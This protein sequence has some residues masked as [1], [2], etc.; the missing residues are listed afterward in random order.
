MAVERDAP[1]G[2]SD[3]HADRVVMELVFALLIRPQGLDEDLL[4]AAQE[5]LTWRGAGPGSR[6][7]EFIE[8]E[9]LASRAQDPEAIHDDR[10]D[11]DALPRLL[12]QRGKATRDVFDATLFRR[13]YVQTLLKLYS[14][15]HVAARAC[16]R[17]LD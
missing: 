17:L 2:L 13:E 15:L 3:V 1:D 8:R 12:D 16:N 7:A 4:G 11:R 6:A 14:V 9:R 5:H 10:I